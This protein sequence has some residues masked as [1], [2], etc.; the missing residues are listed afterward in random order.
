[1]RLAIDIVMGDDAS[2]GYKKN[3]FQP[4]GGGIQDNALSADRLPKSV[5]L[6]PKQ[7][8]LGCKLHLQ[9]WQ[10]T[11]LVR[12]VIGLR[13]GCCQ[14]NPLNHTSMGRKVVL[15]FPRSLTAC[16]F[17]S[18]LLLPASNAAL[19]VARCCASFEGVP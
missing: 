16:P 13:D 12:D 4:F 5:S 2:D 1:M 19:I 7:S 8:I 10:N 9:V 14:G 3:N 15:S 17:F 6:C 11:N 18:L